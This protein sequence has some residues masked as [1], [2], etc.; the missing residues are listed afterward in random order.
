MWPVSGPRA[1]RDFVPAFTS[2]YRG[3]R[4]AA[5][6]PGSPNVARGS[7]RLRPLWSGWPVTNPRP[8]TIPEATVARLAVYLRVLTGL[9]DG[10]RGTVSPR[11][12]SPPAGGEPAG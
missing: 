12:R 9:V 6:R 1:L 8:R 3:G 5:D 7:S 11:G 10:G 4:R 2:G